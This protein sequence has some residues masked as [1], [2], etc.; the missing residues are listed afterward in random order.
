MKRVVFITLVA[1]GLC[2]SHLSAVADVKIGAPAPEFTAT[3]D[4]G[5]SHK[6][7]DFRGKFVVLEWHNNGCPYVQ[8]HYNSGSMQALQKTWT[9]KGVAWLTIVSSAPGL[10]GYVTPEQSQTYVKQMKASPTAVLLDP[11]GA[12]GHLY[13]AKTSPQ[14]IVIDPKGVVIYNGAIDNRPTPDPSSLTGA[15]NYV[16]QTLTEALAGKPVS[17]PVSVPY[18]CTIKYKN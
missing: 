14:M 18:G 12:V 15:T 9:D 6:L 7:S 2:A 17:T 4:H 3:D 1:L 10:Q 16:N 11:T 8:K 13:D 5:V